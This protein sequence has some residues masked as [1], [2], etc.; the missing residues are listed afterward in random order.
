MFETEK[1]LDKM[2]YQERCQLYN[3]HPEEYRRVT[4]KGTTLSK[5]VSGHK[6]SSQIRR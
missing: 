5:K 2:S 4:H 3:D 1:K 6:C